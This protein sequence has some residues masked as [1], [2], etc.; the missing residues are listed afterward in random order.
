MKPC[1]THLLLVPRLKIGRALHFFPLFDFMALIGATLSLS[2]FPTGL[3]ATALC[4]LQ[5][6]GGYL[7]PV[8]CQEARRWENKTCTYNSVP[9]H[10]VVPLPNSAQG[11]EEVEFQTYLT[12]TIQLLYSGE[13]AAVNQQTGG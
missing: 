3:G 4:P 9:T 8:F 13:I 1:G 7:E 10:T 12:P 11:G 5:I 2:V 6:F